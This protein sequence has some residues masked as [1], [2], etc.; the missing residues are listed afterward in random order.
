MFQRRGLLAAPFALSAA[1]ALAQAPAY[2]QRPVRVVIPWP[3]GQA[4]DLAARIV[5]QRLSETMGQPFVAENRAGAGGM[6]GTDLAAKAA[7]DGY[8]LLAGSTGP[9]VTAPLVQ[10][11]PYDSEKDFTWLGITGLSSYVLVVPP[12]FPAQN[13]AEFVALVRANPGKYSFSSSGTGATAHVIA[14]WFH[15]LAGLDVVH[16]PFAGSGPALTAVAGGH[17]N[18]SVETLAGTGPLIRTGTLRAL[19]ISLKNG[20]E[21]A[22]NIPPLARLP[23]CEDF[24]A[25]A[26][27]GLMGPANMPAPVVQLLDAAIGSAMRE[28][29]MRQRMA[30]AGLEPQHHGS[31]AMAQ[32]ASRQRAAFREAIQRANIR[33]DG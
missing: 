11:T 15:A 20:S 29:E 25:G 22:P 21:L 17:V 6:I 32:Y 13:A 30:T 19:G 24:D 7:P 27:I 18:F 33:I 26:W 4:T 28:P 9:I 8:T 10:R 12:N 3:P 5:M 1:P 2:P 23:G 31:A 16:V 14:A